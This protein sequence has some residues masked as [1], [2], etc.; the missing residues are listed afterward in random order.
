MERR[1]TVRKKSIIKL[2]GSCAAAASL[3]IGSVGAYSVAEA[4]NVPD[5]Q[6]QGERTDQFVIKYKDGTD[7]A[8]I[9]EKSKEVDGLQERLPDD[10]QKRIDD[11]VTGEGVQVTESRAT[12]NGAAAISLN[13]KLTKESS[14]ALVDELEKDPDVEFVEPVYI[15]HALDINED[16]VRR[17]IY[18]SYQWNL[19]NGVGGINAKEAWANSRGKGV[20]VAV[21][22]T[23]I[24]SHPE[25]DSQLV[26]GIDLIS[27][28]YRARDNN[29]R[30]SNPR[31]EGDWMRAGEC[32]GGSPRQDQASSWHGTHVA[33]I[34]GARQDGQGVDGVAPDVKIEPIR[35]LGKCGG[36]SV[37]IAAGITW[38]SGGD[39]PGLPRNE[40]PAQVINMSLGGGALQCPRV[41]QDAI[42]AAI[43]RGT[44]IVVAAGNEHTDARR[45]TPANCKGVITVGA[46][47]PRGE[48]S[49][50]SN[51]GPRVD[52]SAPG[53][54]GW[55]ESQIL[56]AANQ[57]HFRPDGKPNF[58]HMNGTS[59]AT[60]HV[61]GVA[62]LLK[63][64]FPNMTPEQVKSALLG[65]VKPVQS[66]QVGGCGKGILNA[67]GALREAARI[68][69]QRL[70]DA[71]A[72]SEPVSEGNEKVEKPGKPEPT[73][74]PAPEPTPAPVPVDDVKKPEPTESTPYVRT[75]VRMD[76]TWL[77]GNEKAILTVA[78][79]TAGEEAVV[80]VDNF[81]NPIG[82]LTID[83]NG[84]RRATFI[85]GNS[86]SY[87]FHV[88]YVK[89]Q[90]SQKIAGVRFYSNNR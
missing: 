66:C 61:A 80:Y 69:K 44:T 5:Q 63:S 26:Q 89:G 18:T 19:Q 59:Q 88:I 4:A 25:L 71:P 74:K 82:K 1:L 34:I 23:G 68:M 41:Y 87:G 16:E 56:S 24:V 38:A 72:P 76:K 85:P 54:N 90:T 42:D 28:P 84:T 79:L 3:V 62:A 51:Y 58:I 7:A 14:E 48:Q 27:D 6:V 35:V 36:T 60:P 78:G 47:G 64:Q 49:S 70:K 53:G 10:E 32:G 83:A 20:T 30:D 39:V 21:L 75:T 12:A 73:P 52:L 57:S 13:K 86:L 11:A 8:E 22:D 81:N 15:A 50:Y 37:D 46:T 45:A 29:G 17:G 77:K 67:P 55:G 33:G 31:D 2:V 65:S 43:A 40:H 9:I